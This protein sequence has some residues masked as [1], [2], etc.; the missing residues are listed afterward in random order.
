MNEIYERRS[1]RRYKAVSIAQEVIEQILKAGIAAPSSKN[2][3]PWRF[4]VATGTAKEAAL[5]AMENGLGREKTNPLLPE[6]A[7]YLLAAW[8]TLEVM[9]TA[10][11]VVFIVNPLA[12]PLSEKMSAEER[13]SDICNAQSVGAAIENMALT[14]TELGLGSLW[15]CDT[16]FAQKELNEW[17]SVEGELYATMAFGIPDENPAARPRYALDSVV[18]WRS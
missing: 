9:K 18:E 13:V 4:I 14:A 8:H 3:Q 6:S 1:I 17:L 2:R 7:E 11:V 16:F 12:K 5:L 10:P 15:I